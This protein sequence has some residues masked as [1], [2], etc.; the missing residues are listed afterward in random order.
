MMKRAYTHRYVYVK[1]A[2]G[3]AYTMGRGLDSYVKT[4]V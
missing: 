2:L 3:W 4:R 1:I